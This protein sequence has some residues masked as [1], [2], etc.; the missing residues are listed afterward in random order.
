MHPVC[1]IGCLP[2]Y[3]FQN[4]FLNFLRNN[5]STSLRNTQVSRFCGRFFYRRLRNF[6]SS[7]R[8]RNYARFSN[9]FKRTQLCFRGILPFPAVF[10]AP[11]PN[12]WSD[13]CKW[14]AVGKML[15]LRI[16]FIFFTFQNFIHFYEQFRK[17]RITCSVEIR[18]EFKIGTVCVDPSGCGDMVNLD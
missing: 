14:Y 5:R 17:Y 4:N 2:I 3:I 16:F 1:W 12:R 7:V 15:T 13:W 9:N 11:F 10:R 18:E 6:Y 8:F